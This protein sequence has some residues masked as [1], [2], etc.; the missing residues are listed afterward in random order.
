MSLFTQNI[1]AILVIHLYNLKILFR[2]THYQMHHKVSCQR[3]KRIVA[4]LICYRYPSEW[5]PNSHGTHHIS[6]T[7]GTTF[8][9]FE[10]PKGQCA[11]D[12]SPGFG[13]DLVARSSSVS[14]HASE[15]NGGGG[16]SGVRTVPPAGWPRRRCCLGRRRR[17]GSRIS[18]PLSR[19]SRSRAPSG[20]LCGSCWGGRC[21]RWRS[22]GCTAGRRWC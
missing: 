8:S 19:R 15:S 20:R 5:P 22:T 17:P 13:A 14:R 16:P 11:R 1:Q 18:R 4:F 9:K 7:A 12:V 21:S 6:M 3:R 2:Q 10:Q